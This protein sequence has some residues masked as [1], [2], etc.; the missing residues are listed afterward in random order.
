[1]KPAKK[2]TTPPATRRRIELLATDFDGTL[3]EQDNED[4]PL[5][6]NFFDRLARL[7]TAGPVTW[8]INTGRP[9]DEIEEQLHLRQVPVWP[10]WVVVLE[11]EIWRVHAQRKRL[12][13]WQEWNERCTIVHNELFATA[14]P[15]WREVEIFVRTQTEAVF[16]EDPSSP[17]ALR[18]KDHD[19]AER[20]HAH[21]AQLIAGWPGLAISR[22]HI[23]FRFSHADYHKGSCLQAVAR[24]LDIPR[25]HVMAIG[26]NLND[27]PMLHLSVAGFIACPS[28]AAEP[29]KKQV[30]RERGYVAQSADIEGVIESLDHFTNLPRKITNSRLTK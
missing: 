13:S 23:W 28:N 6:P 2:T 18:A 24:E 15:F 16:L 27:L 14:A 22:A 10:D 21:L 9:L 25:T 8:V 5:N 17:I 3:I 29:V 11:R 30:H 19:E 20:I 1:M 26:D 4:T 7:R 12:V